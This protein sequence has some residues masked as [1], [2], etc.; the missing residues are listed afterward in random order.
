MPLPDDEALI[1]LA[2]QVLTG[3]E[4]GRFPCWCDGAG[5]DLFAKS[6][7]LPDP[8]DHYIVWK[9]WLWTGCLPGEDIS[10]GDILK[11]E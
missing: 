11:N 4:V 9:L 6:P 7:K 3:A 8:M 1:D 5:V 10:T 2:W